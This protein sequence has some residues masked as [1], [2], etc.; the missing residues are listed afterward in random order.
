M[1]SSP[2]RPTDPYRHLKLAAIPALAGILGLVLYSNFSGSDAPP[3]QV[4]RVVAAPLTTQPGTPGPA[5]P[6]PVVPASNITVPTAGPSNRAAITPWPKIDLEE[7]VSSDPFHTM[8][9]PVPA[10]AGTPA[11]SADKSATGPTGL[12]STGN[13]DTTETIAI[14]KVQAI[15]RDTAGAAAILDSH[16]V[17]PGDVLDS[18]AVVVD[19]T[20]DGIVV[21]TLK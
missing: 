3:S 4:G 9:V 1:S 14:G 12:T 13:V 6:A 7:I 21:D 15:Y 20:P 8:N 11:A 16:V 17:R 5:Q 18:G 10:E 2:S 19:V